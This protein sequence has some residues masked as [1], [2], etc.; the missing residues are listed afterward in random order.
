[1]G[2][3]GGGG[4]GGEGTLGAVVAG[5]GGTPPGGVTWIW[6]SVYWLT[7]AGGEGGRRRRCGGDGGA[8]DGVSLDLAVAD[9]AHG[10]GHH[11]GDDL[12]LAVGDGLDQG[13]W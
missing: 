1:M 13:W 10:H 7:G 6:P 2:A 11:G 5:G 4:G 12:G 8:R 9:L 3:E